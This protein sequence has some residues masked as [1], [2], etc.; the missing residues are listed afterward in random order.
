M[1]PKEAARI[2]GGGPKAFYKYESVDVLQRF[3]MDRLLRLAD[4]VG[5]RSVEF[6]RSPEPPELQRG[7]TLTDPA[8]GY[9]MVKVKPGKAGSPPRRLSDA[10]PADFLERGVARK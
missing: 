5:M 3:A 8:A 4:A 9:G 6:L 2:L 7:L 1:S 10:D